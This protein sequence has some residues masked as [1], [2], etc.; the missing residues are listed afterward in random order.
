VLVNQMRRYGVLIFIVAMIAVI[1][2]VGVVFRDR[3]GSNA[4]E[5]VV[6]E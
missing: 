4:S 6:G 1:A 2:V 3:Y 5:L